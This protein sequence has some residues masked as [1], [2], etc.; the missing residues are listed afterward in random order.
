VNHVKAGPDRR[1]LATI[2]N[3]QNGFRIPQKGLQY[4]IDGIE[5]T[6]APLTGP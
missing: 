4:P 2:A 5:G 1:R 3:L 6:L